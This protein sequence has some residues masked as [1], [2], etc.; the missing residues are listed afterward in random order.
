M[1]VRVFIKRKFEERQGKQL[2]AL[3]HELRTI[4]TIQ[5]GYVSGET[6]KRI[7]EGGQSLV[8]SKWKSIGYW[9]AWLENPQRSDLQSKIDALLDTETEYEVYEFG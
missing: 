6:L 1:A 8:I 3:I 5:P 9:Q 7:D 2:M 4:S